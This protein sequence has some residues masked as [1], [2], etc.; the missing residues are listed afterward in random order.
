MTGAPGPGDIQVPPDIDAVIAK[1][2]GVAT[3]FDEHTVREALIGARDA[4]VNPT[5]ADNLGAWAEVLAFALMPNRAR[6]SPWNSYFGPVA[7]GTKEDG[8]PYYSPDIAGTEP[9]VIG[10]WA[11]RARELSHPVLK[12]RYADLSWD[13][14]RAIARSNPDPDM[15]RIA[16]DAYLASLDGNARS[17]VHDRFNVTLRALNLAVM[18]RDSARVERAKIALLTL[19]R[20]AMNVDRGPW[21][22]AFER[23]IDDKKVG[24]TDAERDRL[25]ADLEGI[26][27][28]RSDISDPKA[29][30]PFDVES[31]AGR[32]IKHYRKRN[33]VDDAKHLHAILGRTF[34]HFASLG[35]AMLASAH[36]Q[37]AVNAYRDAGLPAESTRARI[38]ME[39]KIAQSHDEASTFTFERLIPKE[40]MDK[41]MEELVVDDLGLT[42]ARIAGAFLQSQSQ[43]ENNVKD[44]LEHAPL[45]AMIGQSI[46]GEHHVAAKVG[47]V[48][49]DPFG[50][51]IRQ[52]VDGIALADIWLINALDRAI[53]R[54]DLSPGH[55]AGWAGRSG[56]FDDLTLLMEGIAA[57]FDQDYVKAVHVLVPQVEKG[58]RGIAAKLNRP[59]TKP[60]P[61]LPGVGVAI[62]MGDILYSDEMRERLGSELTLHFLTLY[63]DPRGFNLRNEVAHG[64]IDANG[65]HQAVATRIIHTLLVFGMWKVFSS[66]RKDASEG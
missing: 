64:L 14:S 30:N 36:L 25:T 58:L 66:Q 2:D 4:L 35:N 65:M 47:S 52:A 24:L 40:D 44:T 27:A 33:R 42:F 29:F 9:Q 41:A 10:H 31:A 62:G 23:L 38:A 18:I 3:R 59:I 48:T 28:K 39:Q 12:A 8:S 51:L 19:H 13:L 50:R 60:H 32:L 54:H 53:E 61:T 16:I 17:D 37:T 15:A 43:L 22:I 11:K 49:E 63:A 56:L 5:A 57:W 55:F 20:Y 21:W 1:F 45:M 26:I 46:I 7:S 6:S 34:E